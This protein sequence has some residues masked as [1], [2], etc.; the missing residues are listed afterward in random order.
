MDEPCIAV[1]SGRACS[2]N[3]AD[4][5]WISIAF[6]RVETAAVI[7]VAPIEGLIAESGAVDMPVMSMIV[8]C[9][10]MINVFCLKY[11]GYSKTGRTSAFFRVLRT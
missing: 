10:L 4:C 1:G 11:S 3:S 2:N 7:R 5:C 6:F 8:P 9:T